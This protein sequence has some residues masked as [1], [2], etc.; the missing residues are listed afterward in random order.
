LTI[1]KPVYRPGETIHFRSLSLER[2]SL[3]P[4]VDLPIR[5]EFFDPSG[6]VVAG[7]T[8][9]GV[10]ERGVGNGEFRIP[11][12]APGG[13]YKL[14]AKS[15]DGFFPEESRTLQVRNYRAPRF[16]KDLEFKKR[17]YGP[18]ELVEADFEAIRA[19]GGPLANQSI[20]I[21]ATVDGKV[22]YQ[23][24]TKTTDSGTCSISFKLPE[25][26]SKGA[27]LLSVSVFDKSRSSSILKV[28]T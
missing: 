1:D 26:I 15:L 22:V 8:F 17:S 12:S 28:D 7:G 18:G 16:K 6:A 23:D 25:L 19:E 9:D 5:F 21:A 13:Q 20:K 14:V 24:T 11:T 2:Y 27:A 10:T 3:Q 4:N